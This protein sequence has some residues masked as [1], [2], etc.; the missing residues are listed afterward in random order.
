MSE[1]TRF[2]AQ[3]VLENLVAVAKEKLE[4]A[5][6]KLMTTETWIK[7]VPVSVK[8]DENGKI[9]GSQM[10]SETIE[11]PSWHRLS[12]WV[13]QQFVKTSQFQEATAALSKIY[14]AKS[15]WLIHPL[16]SFLTDML[17]ERNRNGNMEILLNDLE[18]KPCEWTVTVRLVGVLPDSSIRLGDGV[19]LRRVSDSDLSFEIQPGIPMAGRDELMQFY[20]S[21]MEISLLE[22][23]PNTVQ[24]KVEKL[25]IL[26]SLF[27][28]SSA[29]YQSY[30][31]RAKSYLQFGGRPF[32]MIPPAGEPRAVIHDNE[33]S[34]LASFV[35]QFEPRIPDA[36]LWGKVVDPL[37]IAMKRYLESVRQNSPIEERLMTAVMGLE[38]L[39]LE[40]ASELRFRLALRTA[41]ILRHLGENSQDVHD[42][43]S[44]A[45]RYRSS[46]VHGSVLL[47]KDA[48]EIQEVTRRVWRYL[49]KS[50]LFWLAEGIA[51][52]NKKRQLLKDIDSSLIDDNKRENLKGRMEAAKVMMKG[53]L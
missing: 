24:K 45:Y 1:Q 39:F 17:I 42:T 36:A 32:K 11:K 53:A 51:S 21:V 29:H 19:T 33:S 50:L 49:R 34:D 16:T 10:Y 18:H 37:E 6:D 30:D 8:R 5:K 25:C 40:E 2:D 22:S 52:E 20:D 48:S 3:K 7:Y 15:E 41:Q 38:A 14:D 9:T 31:M 28:E 44:K 13:S 43:V 46:H 4:P 23:Y 27:K 12:V 26:L 47:E 35:Q